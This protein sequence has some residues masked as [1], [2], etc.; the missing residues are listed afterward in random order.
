VSD[1]RTAI[2]DYL[3]N[4]RF[5]ADTIDLNGE[6]RLVSPGRPQAGFTAITTPEYTVEATEYREGQF[7]FTEKFPGLPTVND[8]TFS[9]GVALVNTAFYDWIRQVIEGTGNYRATVQI[10]HFHR[11]GSLPQA[12]FPATGQAVTTRLNLDQPARI[13]KC[14]QAFPIRDKIAADLEGTAA[15][16]SIQEMDVSFEYWDVEEINPADA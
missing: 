10:K 8:L 5:H 12:G 6:D 14:Y 1:P 15:D 3:H 11:V 2:S 13:Y 16:I 4:F 7:V 9:Q